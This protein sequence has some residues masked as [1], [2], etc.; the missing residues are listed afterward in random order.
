M[1][2]IKSIAVDAGGGLKIV[3][4]KRE[5]WKIIA[6]YIAEY[7]AEE[8][9][10]REEFPS[11]MEIR[12]C[13]SKASCKLLHLLLSASSSQEKHHLRFNLSS[14]VPTTQKYRVEL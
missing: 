4:A 7:L 2:F 1:T 3:S 5:W 13:K 12:E 11:Q 9:P 6:Q 14:N 10:K 8:Q